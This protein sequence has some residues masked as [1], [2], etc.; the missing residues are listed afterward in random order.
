VTAGNTVKRR[1]QKQRQVSETPNAAHDYSNSSSNN[2]LL[3]LLSFPLRMLSSY[4]RL[5]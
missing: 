1:K 5:L 2:L 4:S 3:H